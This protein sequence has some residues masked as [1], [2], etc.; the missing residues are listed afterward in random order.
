MSS[1]VPTWEHMLPL[2]GMCNTYFLCSFSWPNYVMGLDSKEMW[3]T[4]VAKAP[5]GGRS[6]P[7]EGA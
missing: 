3:Y 4:L 5:K 2:T 1:L 6:F 7:L